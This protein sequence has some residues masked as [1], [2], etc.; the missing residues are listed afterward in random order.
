[1]PTSISS[2]ER[3]YPGPRRV[4]YFS[5][6]NPASPAQQ[7]T[8]R[9]RSRVAKHR[10]RPCHRRSGARLNRRSQERR[11]ARRA[12]SHRRRLQ[13]PAQIYD[14]E[15]QGLAQSDDSTIH[16]TGISQKQMLKKFKGEVIYNQEVDKHFPHLT[17]GQ[18]L[19][20][21]TSRPNLVSVSRAASL[22]AF[23]SSRQITPCTA[24]RTSY[25]L[26]L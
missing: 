13:H 7:H 8:H 18:T 20:H 22:S 25:S 21:R 23:P 10:R 11:V 5:H 1:M 16:Y 4:E 19:S 2:P 24:C 14:G 6:Y 17:A 26:S 12:G 9:G 15:M 3:R